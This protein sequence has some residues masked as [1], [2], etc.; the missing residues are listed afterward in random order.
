MICWINIIRVIKM[1][2]GKNEKGAREILHFFANEL[3]DATCSRSHHLSEKGGLLTHLENTFN[4]A[5]RYF[6]EDNVLQFLALIHDIGKARTYTDYADAEGKFDFKR[7]HTDH[8]VNTFIM[9]GEYGIS[10]SPEEVNAIQFHHGGWSRYDGDMTE[11]AVKLHF[12]DSLATAS[13]YINGDKSSE[14]SEWL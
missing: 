9:L 8:T 10:L 1:M 7:P 5:K 2:I 4:V 12:C 6:P 11:L 13:E 3:K 14:V